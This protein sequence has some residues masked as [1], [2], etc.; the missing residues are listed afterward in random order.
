MTTIIVVVCPK[1][2]Q[3]KF[4]LYHDKFI[5]KKV[6]SNKIFQNQNIVSPTSLSNPFF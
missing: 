4:Q 6:K 1:R 3:K 2:K 5:D